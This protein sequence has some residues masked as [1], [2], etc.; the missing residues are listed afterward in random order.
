MTEII[1]LPSGPSLRRPLPSGEET[2][3]DLRRNVEINVGKVCNNKCVFCLDGMPAT[4]YRRY[5][6]WPEMQAEIK[7]WYDSGSRSL[8]FLGGEPTTY[9]WILDAIAYG[10]DLG[11]TRITLAT[12]GTKFFREEFVD[13][14]IEA[15]LTRVTMSIHGH[16]AA[17]EDRLTRVPGNFDKKIRGLKTL[18]ARRDGGML[19]DNVSINIVLNGWNFRSLPSMLRF[20]FELGLDDIRANFV[21]VEGYAHEDRSL[22]P[23]YSEVIPYVMKAIVLN[24]HRYHRTFTL[25]GF[26]LCVLPLPL[27]LSPDLSRRYIGEFRDLD[28]DCSIFTTQGEFSEDGVARVEGERARFNWQDR[29]RQDLKAHVDTCA[30]CRFSPVCEGVWRGYLGVYGDGEFRA[31][32]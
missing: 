11:Y 17:M 2:F 32:P 12:N 3:R 8:G 28:T 1:S 9:P 19:R 6:P 18:M 29:K 25:G 15:G 10:R 4:E 21:R 26:P 7:R 13:K 30:R 31:L 27:L 14:V 22:I 16:T 24:E 5:L 23:R 20:F